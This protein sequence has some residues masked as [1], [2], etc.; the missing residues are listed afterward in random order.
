MLEI[1]FAVWSLAYKDIFFGKLKKTGTDET[2][3]NVTNCSSEE[4]DAI[5]IPHPTRVTSIF[6]L[7]G[8][9]VGSSKGAGKFLQNQFVQILTGEGKSVT[10]AA[11]STVL[12]LCGYTVDCACYSEYLSSRDHKEFKFLF[13][14]FHV[15]KRVTYGTFGNLCEKFI[16]AKGQIRDV[17]SNYNRA[18]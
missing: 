11:V 7:L 16:N 3:K 4:R 18:A 8:I 1:I 15:L 5:R 6:R 12:A 2:V 10:L 9:G 13:E 14:A 17:V